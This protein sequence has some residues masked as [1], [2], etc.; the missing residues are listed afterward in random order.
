[1]IL[2]IA[3]SLANSVHSCT[4]R[5]SAE[6]DRLC[7]SDGRTYPGSCEL[8]CANFWKR[9]ADEPCLTKIADGECPSEP[10]VCTEPCNQTCGSDGQ[11]YGNECILK[12]AQKIK[13]TLTKVSDG[14]C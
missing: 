9:D 6:K 3:V 11:T 12:C 10:C 7:A 8:F 4:C 14:S 2:G 13:P 1:M 5:P